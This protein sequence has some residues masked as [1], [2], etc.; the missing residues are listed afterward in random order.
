MST[1]QPKSSLPNV[2]V[3]PVYSARGLA[4]QIKDGGDHT[5]SRR[6]ICE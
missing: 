2:R 4:A 3:P 6:T 1:E 5:L